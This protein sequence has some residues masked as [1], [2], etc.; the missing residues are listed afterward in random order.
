LNSLG[1]KTLTFL[2]SAPAE[3]V[4]LHE[5]L[6]TR[7][8]IISF[9][10]LLGRE[11]LPLQQAGHQHDLD[12]ARVICDDFLQ[13][14]SPPALRTQWTTQSPSFWYSTQLLG[15]LAFSASR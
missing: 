5:V 7:Y 11:Y 13:I 2:L 10:H 1:R 8:F 4:E 3:L 15:L 9:L 14:N 6:E 12:I